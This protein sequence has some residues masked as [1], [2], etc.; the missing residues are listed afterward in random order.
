MSQISSVLDAQ[1]IVCAAIILSQSCER[2]AGDR[3]NSVRRQLF[4]ANQESPGAEPVNVA[5]FLL[6]SFGAAS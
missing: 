6:L 2:T 4:A 1:P 3:A 5:F